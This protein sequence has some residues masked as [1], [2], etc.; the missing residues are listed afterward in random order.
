MQPWTCQLIIYA[1][2]N[3][4]NRLRS[5]TC[6][7]QPL[8]PVSSLHLVCAC[9]QAI[10]LVSMKLYDWFMIAII[11]GNMV[12][13]AMS[14]NEPGFEVGGAPCKRNTRHAHMHVHRRTWRVQ[15]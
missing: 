11:L 5:V 14:S 12:V 9:V 10:Q 1:D 8:G 3:N 13:L 2:N 15:G 4:S 7:R 6:A